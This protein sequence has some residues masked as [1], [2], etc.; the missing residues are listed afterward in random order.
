[1]KKITM[2]K[3]ETCPYC[4][5]ALRLMDALFAENP[6]YK[7]LDIEIIDEVL[8]PEISDKYNYRLV[9]AYYIGDE[10]LHD[11]AASLAIIRRVFDAAVGN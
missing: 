3:I 4:K 8:H 9:P 11:G 7:S 1:M 5:E 10:K 2:F 6:E